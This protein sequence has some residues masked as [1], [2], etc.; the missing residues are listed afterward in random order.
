MTPASTELIVFA[1]A[2]QAFAKPDIESQKLLSRLKYEPAKDKDPARYREMVEFARYDYHWKG[3][4]FIVYQL[5]KD[6]NDDPPELHKFFILYKREGA[7]LVEGRPKAVRELI[8]AASSNSQG[9]HEQDVLV[10]DDA[11]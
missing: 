10:F 9:V 11:R 2:G 6:W 8:S 4:G 7:E 5:C 1:D 3:N